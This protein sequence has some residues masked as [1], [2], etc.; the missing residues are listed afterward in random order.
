MVEVFTLIAL[1]CLCILTGILCLRLK[2]ARLENQRLLGS[3]RKLLNRYTL[4]LL[5]TQ[6]YLPKDS[7]IALEIEKEI[8]TL[9]RASSQSRNS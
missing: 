1:G 7:S 6:K 4:I 2:A 3:L 8:T 5:S 9:L